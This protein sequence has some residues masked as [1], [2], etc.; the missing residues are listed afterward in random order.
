[1][2]W[3]VVQV[4]FCRLM[5][6]QCSWCY[7]WYVIMNRRFVTYLAKY[8]TELA[9]AGIGSSITQSSHDLKYIRICMLRLNC[10]NRIWLRLARYLLIVSINNIKHEGCS[11]SWKMLTLANGMCVY[12]TVRAISC[13]HALEGQVTKVCIGNLSGLNLITLNAVG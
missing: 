8:S 13:L 3:E 11:L 2:P 9:V 6:A 5:E 7:W 4:A 10:E 12:T 1:M